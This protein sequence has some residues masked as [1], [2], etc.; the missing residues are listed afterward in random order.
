MYSI[1]LTVWFYNRELVFLLNDNLGFFF[2]RDESQVA[3]YPVRT[4]AP[5]EGKEIQGN[6]MEGETLQ[7]EWVLKRVDTWEFLPLLPFTILAITHSSS[8]SF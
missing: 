3:S 2:N 1:K 8:S 4:E 5:Q 7:S 6:M